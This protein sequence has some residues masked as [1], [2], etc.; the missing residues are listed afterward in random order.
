MTNI[1]ECKTE[2]YMNISENL[3]LSKLSDYREKDNRDRFVLKEDKDVS[4]L[5]Q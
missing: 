5:Y 2:E 3:V 4:F 1:T